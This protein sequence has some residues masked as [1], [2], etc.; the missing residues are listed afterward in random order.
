MCTIISAFTMQE[1]AER[2]VRIACALEHISKIIWGKTEDGDFLS[3]TADIINCLADSVLRLGNEFEAIKSWTED[4]NIQIIHQRY[5]GK[6]I[7]LDVNKADQQGPE[8]LLSSIKT[9][10]KQ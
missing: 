3:D 4:A 8:V 7:R 9:K 2:A 10:T 6:G 5:Y 1:N